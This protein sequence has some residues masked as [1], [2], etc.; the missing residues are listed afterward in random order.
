MKPWVKLVGYRN[1]QSWHVR[2]LKKLKPQVLDQRLCIKGTVAELD[3]IAPICRSAW[4][5]KTLA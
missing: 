2:L 1:A 3:I 4:L 5:A